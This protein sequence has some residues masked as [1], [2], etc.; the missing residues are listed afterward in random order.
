MPTDTRIDVP[1][2]PQT[3]ITASILNAIQLAN[4]HHAQQQQNAIR[5]QQVGMQQQALPGEIAQREAQTKLATAQT[6]TADFNL[7]SR[8]QMFSELTGQSL[9]SPQ[10]PDA[11]T[12][13][14][15][16]PK[17]PT[18]IIGNTVN[19]LM[20]DSSLSPT[21]VQAIGLAGR[22]A[23]LK[24]YQDPATAMDGI[25]DTYN[26]ILRQH[27]D[28][29]RAI[30]TDTKQDPQSTTGYS[31]VGTHPDG[32]EA[33]RIASQPPL[34]KS[35]EEATSLLGSAQLAYQ[36][37]PTPGNKSALT[38]FQTQH[39]A[40]YADHLA[41]I[42]K[43]AHI[44]AQSRGAD[45]EAM[46]R[47]GKN[48][49]TGEKLSI[50]NAPPGSLVN[51]TNG[52]PIPQDMISLYKPTMNERQTADTA[53]Q[54]LAISQ[55]LRDQ[56]GKHPELIGPLAGRSQQEIQ[57]LG[58]SSSDA[59]KLIDD[60]TFLQSAATKMHTGRFSSEIMQKMGSIIK[61]GMNKDE[62]LGSLDS[63]NDVAGRYA[64]EDKLTTAYE[65]QQRQQFENQNGNAAPP[66]QTGKGGF[67]EQFGGVRH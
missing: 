33:Y 19:K 64:N 39:D 53:R 43:Q 24:A 26:G 41:E 62:F 50:D 61:P 17:P 40:M 6:E 4:E 11:V 30:K 1:F 59:A 5:Q 31:I 48:P 37:D 8:K 34:P 58:L 28:N 63:I 45:V 22:Q 16:P 56:I 29:S 42:Q 60:V 51:P 14:G 67:F 25:I 52:Q 7:K 38:L 12:T 65:Y 27:G 47:T 18:G 10:Q 23:M 49:I 13:P 3:G 44:S 15:A 55:D 66:P 32:T 9:D 54:V 20:E 46:W 21:E 57:K 2:L 35:L 36:R